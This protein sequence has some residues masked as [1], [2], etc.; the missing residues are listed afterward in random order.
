MPVTDVT[1][2]TVATT[3]VDTWV[4]RFGCLSHVTTDRCRQFDCALFTHVTRLC[5]TRLHRTTSYHPA[6]N[7]MVDQFHKTLKAALTCHDTSWP[8]A[9]PLVLLALQVTPK[10]EIGASPA[11]LVYGQSLTIPGDFVEDVR[12]PRDAVAPTLAE[13]L[14]SHMAG[15]RAHAPTQ[16]GTG[17]I[18]VHTDLQRCM[19]VML[20]TDAVRP[21]LRPPYSGPHRVI[22][23][24]DKTPVL[25]CNGKPL[26]VSVDCVK[27]A[28]VLPAPSAT[29]FFDPA[30]DLIT[31][32]TPCASGQTEP[33]PGAAGNAQLQ[34]AVI[35]PP[36]APPTTTPRQLVRPP[37]PRPP[38]VHRSPPPQPPADYV[39]RVGRRVR[40]KQPCC[41]A[42]MPRHPNWQ[43]RAIRIRRP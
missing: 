28:H 16:H 2:E 24:G 5:G 10:E 3:F 27:P 4:E 7:G 32:D 18:F 35:A 15:L 38:Q 31:D 29:H 23:R 6:L 30:E 14:R 1:A 25:E 8:E 39:T 41:V 12:L 21:P 34:P 43:S 36:R 19:H 13:R 42:N 9:L 20:R 22:A 11:D 17:K 26:T 40:L 37:G 33:A